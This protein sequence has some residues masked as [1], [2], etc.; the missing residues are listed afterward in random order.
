[1]CDYYIIMSIV[2]K[3]LPPIPK[4]VLIKFGITEHCSV[5]LS[6]EIK[7]HLGTNIIKDATNP[8]CD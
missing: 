7:T 5:Y 4:K 2:N 1:M 6:S 3:F 8:K